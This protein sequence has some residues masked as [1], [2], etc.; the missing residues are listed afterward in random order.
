ADRERRAPEPGDRVAGEQH[1][2]HRQVPRRAQRPPRQAGQL[3]APATCRRSLFARSVPVAG[4]EGRVPPRPSHL[5]GWNRRAERQSRPPQLRAGTHPPLAALAFH[6]ASRSM[7]DEVGSA[8]SRE[9]GARDPCISRGVARCRS[10]TPAPLATPSKAGL[11]SRPTSEAHGKGKRRDRPSDP[12]SS[13]PAQ[14]VGRRGASP[15]ELVQLR[16]PRARIRKAE[17]VGT[18]L[19]P[20][21]EGAPMPEEL[22][23]GIDVSK[24]TLDVAVLPSKES[25]SCPN[26]E[27]GIIDLVG[28]LRELPA[29]KLVLMEATGGL[30]RQALAT[31]AAAGFP[32]IAVNPR[33]VRDFAKSVGILAKTDA[34]DAHV[35]ALFADRIRPEWRP[36]PDEETQALEA[37]LVRRRQIVDMITA[38]KNRLGTTPS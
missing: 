23:V 38:E 10:H 5:K 20:P 34:I 8:G 29:P 2:D 6:L 28:R 9:R 3:T 11:R 36:L 32:A 12:G 16:G 27:Q 31:I 24:A 4:G 21:Q 33:N 37:L 30:E 35:L 15:S 7:A 17:P 13:R 18:K 26:S 22:F 1:R 14:S 19:L 25:W